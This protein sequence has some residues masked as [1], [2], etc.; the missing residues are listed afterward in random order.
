MSTSQDFPLPENNSDLSRFLTQVEHTSWFTQVGTPVRW[1]NAIHGMSRWEEWPGPGASSTIGLSY[2]QQALYDEI[3]SAS[4]EKRGAL[5]EL[6]NTIQSMVLTDAAKAVPYNPNEDAW[7]APNAAVWHAAWTAGL[8][9]LH[10]YLRRSIPKELQEQ[11][12]WFAQGHWPYG[13]LEDFPERT[14]LVY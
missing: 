1:N 3:M 8:V 11:W 12:N 9:G 10:L 6:W 7:Y 14:L 2:W 4:D 5:A 13:W